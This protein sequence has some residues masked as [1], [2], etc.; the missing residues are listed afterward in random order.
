MN[1]SFLVM[2]SSYV[3][4]QKNHTVE[5]VL[6]A[7]DHFSTYQPDQPKPTNSENFQLLCFS[8]DLNEICYRG[9]YWLE[10]NIEWVWNTYSVAD[11]YSFK[12][13]FNN[14]SL[15]LSIHLL[16]VKFER[17]LGAELI[18]FD[19][20]GSFLFSAFI[21]PHFI[22][23]SICLRISVFLRRRNDEATVSAASSVRGG[24]SARIS[25]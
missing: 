25:L 2:S 9:Q 15:Y 23:I 14:L 1:H 5:W 18:K 4:V 16:L 20:N 17:C 7:Y 22:S 11:H 21:Q 3:S 8:S 19:W 24:I 10:N 12:I 13:F 6:N